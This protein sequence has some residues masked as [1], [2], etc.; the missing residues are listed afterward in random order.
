MS[1][2]GPSLTNTGRT[3]SAQANSEYATQS[4]Q[5][6]VYATMEII[7]DL[8]IGFPINNII[9]LFLCYTINATAS[10]FYKVTA[11]TKVFHEVTAE[12]STK[13]LQLQ[14]FYKMTAT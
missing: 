13:S 2:P 10:V 8:S 6:Q 14:I 9:S 11:R 1:N 12:R 3:K 5:R 4:M 7:H